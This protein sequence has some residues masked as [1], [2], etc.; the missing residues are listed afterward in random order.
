MHIVHKL[1]HFSAAH[2]YWNDQWSEEENWDAF[3]HD[4]RVHG[5]NYILTVSLAGSVDPGT[6]FSA[7]L[8]QLKHLVKEH[9][10]QRLDHT[11]I[12]RDLQWFATRRPS[13]ENLAVWI[14]E[15][16]AERIQGARLY[17]IRLQETESIF[18]DYF[19]PAGTTDQERQLD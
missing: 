11:W 10:I 3:G 9:V 19:G 6:G 16:L 2:R 14:W 18:T 4:V 17:R 15:Q 12:D 1:F 8:H 13:T 7:D 5:H